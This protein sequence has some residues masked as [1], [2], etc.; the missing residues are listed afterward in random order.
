[1][2]EFPLIIWDK[3]P[4]RPGQMCSASEENVNLMIEPFLCTE[5]DGNEMLKTWT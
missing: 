3:I 4:K 1:M 2:I 5:D